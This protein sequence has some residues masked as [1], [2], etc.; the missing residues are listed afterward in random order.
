MTEAIISRY[1]A[2]ASSCSTLSCGSNLELAELKPGEWVLDLGC[3][4]GEEVLRAV[5]LVKPG[6]RAVGLDLTPAMLEQ[7]RAAARDRGEED[8]CEFVLG[9]LTS[10]PFAA[11]TFDCVISN[12][13]INHVEDKTQAYREITRVLK[14]GGRMVISDAVSLVPLPEAVKLDPEARAQCWG[15]AVTEAEYLAAIRATGFSEI[16]IIKRREYM[17]NGYPF[18]S[19]TFKAVKSQEGR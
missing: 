16:A 12:C 18:A 14:P 13:V 19:I 5:E 4:R 17:K 11:D 10:L 6:G 1:T 9:D 15:G 7:A 3:G 2:E 8:A